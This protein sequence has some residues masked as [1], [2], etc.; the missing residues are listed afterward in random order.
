MARD[1]DGNGKRRAI[2]HREYEEVE[3]ELNQALANKDKG[4]NFDAENITLHGY[5]SDWLEDSVRDSVSKR[6]YAS[7]ESH[8]R[9]HIAPAIG[10]V[11]LAKLTPNHV[12]KLYR[13]K[14]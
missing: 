9:I 12:R 11:K 4:F 13:Q 2:Y 14:L 10:R 3:R 5:L 8:V 1:K 6:T 7:Y